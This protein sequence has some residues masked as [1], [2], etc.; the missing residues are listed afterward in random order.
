MMKTP[1][2]DSNLSSF[3]PKIYE[4]LASDLTFFNNQQRMEYI[5]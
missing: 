4:R 3:I 1:S 5:F 2:D